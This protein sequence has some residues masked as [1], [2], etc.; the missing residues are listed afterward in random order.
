MPLSL[1]CG[2]PDLGGDQAGTILYVLTRIR[3]LVFVERWFPG[4]RSHGGSVCE[5][6]SEGPAIQLQRSGERV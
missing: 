6:G 2:S 3:T 1:R 5:G 4:R